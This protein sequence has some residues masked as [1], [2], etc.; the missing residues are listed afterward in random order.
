MPKMKTHQGMN[1]RVKL[2]ARGK[3]LRGR[4]FGNHNFE[5]KSPARKRRSVRSSRFSDSDKSNVRL[6]LRK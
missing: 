3:L 6:L 2:T 5:K 4:A 1:K